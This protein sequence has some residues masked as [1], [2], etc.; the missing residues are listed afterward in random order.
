MRAEVGNPECGPQTA[1]PRPANSPRA[2]ATLPAQAEVLIL[3]ALKDG[4]AFLQAQLDSIAMQRGIRWGLLVSDDGSTDA[5]PAILRAFASRF[6]P[7]QVRMIPGPGRGAAEN[8]LHLLRA[9][10]PSAPFVAFSDQDDVWMPDKLA[11]ARERLAECPV[12]LPAL[13]FGHRLRCDSRLARPRPCSTPRRATGFRNAMVQNIAAGNTL[14]LNRAAVDL[15]LRHEAARAPVP[16]HDWWIYLLVTGAGG[17][18]IPDP[19]PQLL[20]RQH[21]GN[22]LGACNGARGRLRHMMQS[23]SGRSRRWNDANLAALYSLRSA[24]IPENRAAFDSFTAARRAPGLARRL[25]GLRASGVYRHSCAGQL[26]L[27]LLAALN[28]L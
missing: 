24:L 4:A 7:G 8:F 11:R 18:A 6:P 22:M 9:A 2:P 17:R 12:H 27:W 15:V 16:L 20:Y 13:S 1:A 5:G 3:L 23:L 19:Q 28:R 21:R 14:L 25:R 10:D 26:A